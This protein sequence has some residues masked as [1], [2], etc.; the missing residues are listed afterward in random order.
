M[1]HTF[2]VVTIKKWLISVYIYGSY[3]KIKAEVP[4]LNTL[5]ENRYLP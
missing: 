5:Y 2:L 1:R 3:H 4:F